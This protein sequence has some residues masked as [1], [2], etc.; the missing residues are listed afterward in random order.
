ML[1][2]R[3]VLLRHQTPADPARGPWHYDLCVER[4][5]PT[6]G[7]VS[8]EHRLLTLRIP[9]DAEP[10][11]GCERFVAERLPD[12]RVVYL[13]HEG[14]TSAGNDRVQRLSGGR[15]VVRRDAPGMLELE[16]LHD[17][18]TALFAGHPLVGRSGWWVLARVQ[19]LGV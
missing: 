17:G 5:A 12:H 14:P 2:T 11:P 8:A 3:W 18:V 6:A 9:A 15:G 1:R 10:P 19:D 4:A 13:D 7:A 16:L